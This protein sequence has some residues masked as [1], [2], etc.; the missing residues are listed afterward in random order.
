MTKIKITINVKE[1]SWNA[2]KQLAKDS[3][4]TMPEILTEA[5]NNYVGK[6]RMRP[7]VLMH[8]EHSIVHN[9]DLGHTLAK[10]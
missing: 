9:K 6:H 3:N 2:L 7:S 4:K 5:I 1:S 8:L 10:N